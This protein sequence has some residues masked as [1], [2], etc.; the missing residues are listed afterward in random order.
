MN[1]LIANMMCFVRRAHFA[2]TKNIKRKR[3]IGR[4][5]W[6]SKAVSTGQVS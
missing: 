4:C 2:D 5:C 6:K 1:F 3:Q